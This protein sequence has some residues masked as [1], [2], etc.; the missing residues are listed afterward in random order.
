MR[1]GW[2]IAFQPY[3]SPP[4]SRILG[5]VAN[6]AHAAGDQGYFSGSSSVFIKRLLTVSHLMHLQR[7]R[8]AGSIPAE[9]GLY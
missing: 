8:A 2:I 4:K 3:E 6:P 7:D 1:E 5:K 9:R